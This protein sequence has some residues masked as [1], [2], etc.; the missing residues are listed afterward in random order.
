MMSSTKWSFRKERTGVADV[1]PMWIADMDFACAPEIV[2]AVKARAAFPIYGYTQRTD[3]Y[4]DGLINWMTKRHGWN[5]IQR[6]WILFSPGVVAGFSFAI[7]AYSHPGDK[8]VIQ[9]P[10]YYPMKNSILNN[11]RQVVDNPLKIVKGNYVMD[12]EDLE[13]KIDDRTRM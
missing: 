1:L 6:D 4:Y 7:Q 13:K 10:V 3:G 12:Y 11:G 5:G 2:E 9:P 8:V